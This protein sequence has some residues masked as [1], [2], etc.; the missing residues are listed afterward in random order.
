[1]PANRI[2]PYSQPLALKELAA[3]LRAAEKG[4]YERVQTMIAASES[5]I[6]SDYIRQ[7]DAALVLE[8]VLV[9]S[10]IYKGTGRSMA[11]YCE[12]LATDFA[13]THI[14]A[15]GIHIPKPHLS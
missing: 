11:G 15:A 8:A 4:Q 10:S 6:G 5:P 3:I 12:Q 1:L 2:K 9:L 13:L 7:P 14:R